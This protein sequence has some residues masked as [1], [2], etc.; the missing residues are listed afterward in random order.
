MTK[1]ATPDRKGGIIN[2]GAFTPPRYTITKPII[3]STINSIFFMGINI[4]DLFQ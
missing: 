1:K 4:L 3:I 2:L